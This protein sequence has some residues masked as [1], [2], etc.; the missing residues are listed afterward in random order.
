[1]TVKNGCISAFCGI[2][3]I[4]C[5]AFAQ[6]AA[7]RAAVDSA[8]KWL[9]LVDASDYAA[10]WDEAAQFFKNA[11]SKEQWTEKVKAVRAPLGKVNSRKLKSTTY[12]TSLPGAPDGQYVVIQ[13]DSSFENKKSAVET[14]TP[15]MDKDGQWRVTGYFIR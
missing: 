15:M 11:V 1:M 13:F 4:T 9:R 6:P 7:E 3:L 14:V 5:L 10:S 2:L 12:K 8:I